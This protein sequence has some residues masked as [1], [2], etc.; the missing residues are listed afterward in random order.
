MPQRHGHKPLPLQSL[1]RAPRLP[2]VQRAAQAHDPAL[3]LLTDLHHSPCVVASHRDGL[4]ATL[5][6][7]MRAGVRMVFVAGEYVDCH[8]L[9]LLRSDWQA[10]KGKAT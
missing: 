3:S 2:K 7:M 8:A 4:D 6:L 1:Q 9:S 5:H 10:M